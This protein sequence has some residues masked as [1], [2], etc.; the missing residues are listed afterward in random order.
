MPVQLLELRV[1]ELRQTQFQRLDALLSART[2]L[3]RAILD[4]PV[5]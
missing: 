5:V 2:H 1:G 3:S 4:F